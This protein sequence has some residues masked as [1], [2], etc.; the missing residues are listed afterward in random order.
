M[1]KPLG[2]IDP[3]FRHNIPTQLEALESREVPAVY[4]FDFGT[5]TS[6]VATGATAVPVVAYSSTAGFGWE[7]TSGISAVD[8]GG[9]NALTRDVHTGTSKAFLVDVPNGQYDVAVMLGDPSVVRDRVTATAEGATIVSNLT[10]LAG[11]LLEGRGRVTVTDGQ[12][13]LRLTDGGGQNS[14]FAV[15]GLKVSSVNPTATGLG[16]ADATPAVASWNDSAGVEVGMKFQSSVGGSVS[17][18]RFYKGATNTGTHTGSLW[19]ATGQRLATVTF[20]NETATGW[21]TARFNTPVAISPNTTYVVSYYAPK[22]GYAVDQDF[23]TA[24][25]LRSGSLQALSAAEGGNGLYKYGTTSGFPSQSFRGTNYWVDVEFQSGPT[26]APPTANAGADRTAAE[27]GAVTFA[28]SAT[29]SGLTYLWA[30]GDG[31]TATGT[32]T[33]TKTYTDNGTY[34]ATLTVTD[35]LGRT[36][37]DTAVVAVSNVNPTGTFTDNNPLPEGSPVTVTFGSQTDPSSVDRAAGYKYS[38]D[39]NNDGVWDV[40]NSTSPTAQYT[41][42]DNGVYTVRGRITDKDG[43]FTDYTTDVEMSNVNPTAVFSNSGPV[44]VGQAVTASFVGQFDPSA[45]DT[46]FGFRYSY[47]FTNDGTWEVANSTGATAATTFTQAGTYT[48]RGRITDKD[49]GFSEYTSTVT[50]TASSGY[51]GILRT[52]YVSATGTDSGAGSATNPWKTLQYAA[53]NARAGDMIV[54]RA[55]T[56]TG[57]QIYTSG[58]AANPIVFKA[59]PGVLV[60]AKQSAASA[61]SGAINM[62]GASHVAIDGFTVK[63]ATYGS[64]RTGIRSVENTGAV[65]RNNVIDDSSWWGV[66]TGNSA[67]L[68]IENNTITNTRVQHGIYIAN[69]ADNP[70]VRGNR[71]EN[72]RGA[73]IQINADRDLPGDGII[74]NALV[75]NNVLLNNCSGE[76]ASLNLNG[77]EDSLIRNNLIASQFRNGITL[78]QD[79]QTTGCKRNTIIGNTVIGSAFYGIS[80]SGSGTTHNEFYNNILFSQGWASNYRGGLG[81][82]NITGLKSNYNILIGRVNRDPSNTESTSETAAQWQA[83]GFDTNSIFLESRYSSASAALSAL[84]VTPPSWPLY[85]PETGNYRLK[86]GSP[87]INVGTDTSLLTR[88]ILGVTRPSGARTDIGAYEFL[89]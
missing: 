21:Q 56:Y 43:G 54:V 50:V 3:V 80:A 71:V 74:S 8:R 66:L 25:P 27:G 34:T 10:T 28:G 42:Q 45:V 14:R 36:A 73:G 62:E 29:G 82:E 24:S 57:F 20:Q 75:E 47:D 79:N 48:V 38:Y 81:V 60:N 9:A 22:G 23:F 87:A 46:A 89:S 32:L 59:D 83:R 39:V 18:V 6:P 37:T 85:S 30:F 78:Y 41:F 4:S 72:S 53:D 19:S 68:L 12:L 58:T 7:S 63:M 86:A 35:A 2:Q 65:I 64:V 76:S 16:G 11:Q 13:T 5:A 51:S 26:A 88:D 55:G 84:F 69:S 70:V 40:V 33:P 1:S 49:G 31:T 61:Y 67:N 52:M 77:V 15:A 44:T 17:G